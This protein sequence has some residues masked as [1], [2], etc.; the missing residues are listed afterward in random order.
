MARMFNKFGFVLQCI[1]ISIEQMK[2]SSI[3]SFYKGLALTLALLPVLGGQAFFVNVGDTLAGS[4]ASL[5]I[6]GLTGNERRRC[7]FKK[8]R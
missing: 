4:E 8:T 6:S 3:K 1:T 2:L 7:Y 5:Q